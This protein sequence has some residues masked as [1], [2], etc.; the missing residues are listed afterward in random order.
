MDMFYFTTYNTKKMMDK[1]DKS[2]VNEQN[3]MSKNTT[4]TDGI[5]ACV[6]W[7][8]CF[9]NQLTTPFKSINNESPV[10]QIKTAST[11]KWL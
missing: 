10:Y 11:N 9:Y 1:V 3:R 2:T 8:I 4:I 6:C 5:E 7:M